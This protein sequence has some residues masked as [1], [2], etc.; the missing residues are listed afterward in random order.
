MFNI[1]RAAFYLQTKLMYQLKDDLHY[2][3]IEKEISVNLQ[4]GRR[5]V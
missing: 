4:S 1:K 5:Q 2:E 3:V